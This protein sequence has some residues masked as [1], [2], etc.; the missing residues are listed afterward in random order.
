VLLNHFGF[1]LVFPYIDFQVFGG[2]WEVP[3]LVSS[4]FKVKI[5]SINLIKIFTWLGFLGKFFNFWRKNSLRYLT[6]SGTMDSSRFS[7]I[8][9]SISLVLSKNSGFSSSTNWA[10]PFSVNFSFTNFWVYSIFPKI[11]SKFTFVVTPTLANSCSLIK[12]LFWAK[13][14]LFFC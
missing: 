2:A 6:I 14:V 12:S 4:R 5:D 8:K 10:F 13:L 3:E 9:L 1:W 7:Y 11:C